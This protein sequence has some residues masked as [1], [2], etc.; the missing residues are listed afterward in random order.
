MDQVL[1]GDEHIMFDGM[2]IGYSL[3]D[4]WA[5]SSSDL[6]NNTLRGHFAE[7]IVSAACGL[8]LKKP[9]EDWSPYDVY[10]PLD[11]KTG[12]RIEVKTSA[13]LQAWE[14]KKPSRIQFSIRPTRAWHPESGYDQL[15]RHQSDVY[16]FCVYTQKDRSKA[17]P[18]ILDDWEFYV[19][20]TLVIS[21]ACGE[22]QSITLQSL[23]EL[24]PR[25]VDF[26]GIEQAIIECYKL[27]KFP[28]A[29]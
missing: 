3:G 28:P 4:F 9:M 7:F 14:T 22:Q 17:N 8:T 20:S 6:L 24:G 5:W 29:K 12:I 13:Y 15:I 11:Q 25:K 2:P 19:L 27:P 21:T 26:D 23:Q 1:T 16:V 18:L 10:Y